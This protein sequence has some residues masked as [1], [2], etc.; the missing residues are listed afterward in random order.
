METYASLSVCV[1]ASVLRTVCYAPMQFKRWAT[2]GCL[3][4][5]CKVGRP[6]IFL[7]FAPRN[8]THDPPVPFRN[9]QGDI[10][11]M[12]IQASLILMSFDLLV[13]V[14]IAILI[15]VLPKRARRIGQAVCLIAVS[16]PW[17]GR[18]HR[19]FDTKNREFGNMFE[20]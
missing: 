9:R 8:N 3:R 6:N 4:R 12:V 18:H 16:F 20:A 11:F 10:V 14:T 1:A 13:V 7:S 17:A 15:E 19:G 5:Y 2:P